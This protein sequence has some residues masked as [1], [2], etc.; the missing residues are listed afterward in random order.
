MTAVALGLEV[1]GAPRWCY[2]RTRGEQI[3]V[4]AFDRIRKGTGRAK[5]RTLRGKKLAPQVT[6]TEE[7]RAWL[8]E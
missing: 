2:G 4:L 5:K 8:E 7:A 6:M 1:T 3:R